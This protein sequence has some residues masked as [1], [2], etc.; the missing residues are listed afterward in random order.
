M[1]RSLF[2]VGR[3]ENGQL[4]LGHREKINELTIWPCENS[5]FPT[6]ASVHTG[7]QF[8]ILSA[9][10]QRW[11][12]LMYGFTR[13]TCDSV[14]DSIM[15]MCAA[16]GVE[17][18]LAF[19]DNTNGQC[20]VRGGVRLQKYLPHDVCSASVSPITY[21]ARHSIPMIAKTCTDPHS[22][23]TFW[24]TSNNTVYGAGWNLFGQ[25][26]IEDPEIKPLTAHEIK[27]LNKQT[28]TLVRDS[29]EVTK[30]MNRQSIS[31]P[32]QIDAL[33]DK[34]I[35]D[36][37]S[38]G[39]SPTPKWALVALSGAH[40]LALSAN[41][42]V[43]STGDASHGQCGQG[44]VIKS[45][46]RLISS[47]QRTKIR[48]IAVG[49]SHS[50]FLDCNG[51]V[52]CC[53]GNRCGQ[54]GMGHTKTDKRMLPTPIPAFQAKNVKITKIASSSDR[55]LAID[56]E[57]T[58]YAWG[59]NSNGQCCVKSWTGSSGYGLVKTPM[60]I[61]IKTRGS[62]KV[63]DIKC[64]SVHN[65]LKTEDGK[66]FL[67]GQNRDNEVTLVG[68]SWSTVD[69]PRAIDPLFSRLGLEIDRVELGYCATWIWTRRMVKEQ[70][71]WT[72][73]NVDQ[74]R[75]QKRCVVQ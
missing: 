33:S 40:S 7:H 70:N 66:H 17:Q 12:L 61:S 47:L 34:C 48:Q 27:L 41:G 75:E 19:G 30:L 18:S 45:G 5:A 42:N 29:P 38:H 9:D 54:L 64:G 52:F 53:G 56:S 20:G 14:P 74:R 8:T 4:G 57:R 43:Y 32:T 69:T 35:V 1:D 72:R 68:D 10:H 26:G 13:E 51:V 58:A 73:S 28:C 50:V 39:F 23:S 15:M 16:Y 62:S 59:S 65:L 6:V 25:L 44:G 36:I 55:T 71:L 60:A 67:C 63:V 37:R 2:V 49:S 46:W 22:S 31:C 21:F 24:I 11:I 3:N